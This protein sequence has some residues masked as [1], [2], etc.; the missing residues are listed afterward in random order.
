VLSAQ[1]DE[2]MFQVILLKVN[3]R[4]GPRNMDRFGL[5]V[6]SHGTRIRNILKCNIL[7]HHSTIIKTLHL[8]VLFKLLRTTT[9]R[10]P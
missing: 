2:L 10:L 1:A 5:W 4:P 6:T 9:L 8:S 3:I 7:F